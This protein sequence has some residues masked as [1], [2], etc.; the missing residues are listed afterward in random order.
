MRQGLSSCPSVIIPRGGGHAPADLLAQGGGDSHDD[1]DVSII[2]NLVPST[3]K[4]RLKQLNPVYL[5]QKE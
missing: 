5:P 2:F 3:D 1:T 4:L